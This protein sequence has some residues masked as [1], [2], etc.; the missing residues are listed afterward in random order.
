MDRANNDRIAGWMAVKEL[1]K[2]YDQLQPDGT[3]IRTS[4]LHIFRTCPNLI[5]TLPLLQYDEK[6]INDAATE[7]HEVSHA[8][9]ALRYFAISWTYPTEMPK[10]EE[11]DILPFALRD[12]PVR[13]EANYGYSD[14]YLDGM[15]FDE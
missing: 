1:L 4:K 3:T 15:Y 12:D 2:V 7:P 6:K 14:S 11:K 5:R 9:D 8:P 10:K 13:P